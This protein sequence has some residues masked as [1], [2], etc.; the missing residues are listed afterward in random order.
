MHGRL[1]PFMNGMPVLGSCAVYG[2]VGD[3][4]KRS[5]FSRWDQISNDVGA[6]GWQRA[7]PSIGQAWVFYAHQWL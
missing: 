3:M 7:H 1:F 5:R 2:M 4:K 6:D